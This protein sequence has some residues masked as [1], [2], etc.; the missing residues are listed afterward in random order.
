MERSTNICIRQNYL[1]DD[2]GFSYVT[3]FKA[4]INQKRGNITLP[5]FYYRLAIPHFYF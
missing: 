4:V 2:C 1:F 3:S 5:T